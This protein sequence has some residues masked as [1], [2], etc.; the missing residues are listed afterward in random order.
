MTPTTSSKF[1]VGQWTRYGAEKQQ[2][3]YIYVVVKQSVVMET[4]K[5][6][7]LDLSWRVADSGM[8]GYTLIINTSSQQLLP[9][10]HHVLSLASLI[11]KYNNTYLLLSLAHMLIR[12]T[13]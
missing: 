13:V 2:R 9:Y 7:N 12:H 11:K 10:Q 4:N 6:L 8:L 5:I 1:E 3:S